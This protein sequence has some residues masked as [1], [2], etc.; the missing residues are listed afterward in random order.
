MIPD[1][2]NHPY[3]LV[4]YAQISDTKMAHLPS[5]PEYLSVVRLDNSGPAGQDTRSCFWQ[6]STDGHSGSQ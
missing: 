3:V 2:G 5:M 6:G 4:V 1:K